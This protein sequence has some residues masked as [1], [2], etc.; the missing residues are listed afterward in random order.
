MRIQTLSQQIFQILN[1]MGVDRVFL[2][3]GG[4]NLFLVDAVARQKGIEFVPTHHEQAAVIAAEYYSRASEK[5]GV[6]LVTTGPGSTNAVTG[7][8][9]AWLDSIPLLVLAGQVKIADYNSDRAL[10]Q[11]GPQEIDLVSMVEGITKY[12]KTCT[13]SADCI[14]DLIT[15][16]YEASSGRP[17]PVVLEIPL[18]V[19]SALV[20]YE[21][22]NGLLSKTQ[23]RQE[24]DVGL[25]KIYSKICR[26]LLTKLRGAERPLFV[27]GNGVR[28]SKTS[29]YVRELISTLNVPVAL[30][31]PTADFL[32][33]AHALNVG[34]FGNVAKRHSNIL[35][36]KADVVIVLG[37]R[38]DPILTAY[39][40]D[41]FAKNA[42]V[43]VVDVDQAELKKLP[44]RFNKIHADLKFFIPELIN[45]V[46]SDKKMSRYDNWL[47]EIKMLKARFGK[48]SF[49]ALKEV[50]NTISVYDFVD[51]L[52]DIFEGGETI[53][54]GSSGL[55]VEVF[56]THFRNKIGQ[57]LFL[58]T[59][60]GAMGYGL[61]ALLGASEASNEKI[62][63]FE[64]DGSLMMNLQELQSI[65]SRA[66]PATIFVM[67]NDGYASIRTTQKN[68]FEGRFVATGP[69]SGLQIPPIEKIAEC[70][71]FE[72]LRIE[73]NDEMLPLLERA[74]RC[75]GQV[76]CEI[77]LHTDEVLLPKCGVS[78]REDNSLFS[79][80]LE[81]MMPLL[82]IEEMRS[83]MGF[84]FDRASEDLRK[85]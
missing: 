50:S 42:D 14:V 81:D 7:I 55:S 36:Q 44:E 61:P 47:Y 46:S 23:L 20:P 1:H 53:I 22:V 15:A 85:G 69:S 9:G 64:S 43:S 63:L 45:S 71:G 52:S 17:G 13:N 34:R 66:K 65:K 74:L 40:I 24:F 31:W 80:P 59:G 72:F 35:I 5:L 54:T 33:F 79:A 56:Y 78:M 57:R 84:A 6:A 37:S 16:I 49:S 70:F 67:N 62:Y 28:V 11:K 32:P 18:D 77:V 21:A 4:G 51:C 41:K 60:L 19:Q 82:S 39:D 38:L 83:I 27:I 68:Y 30:T 10:R 25:Q 8:A 29:D 26:N 73:S 48:E 76:I 2:V 3:P 75:S 12:S 58:T